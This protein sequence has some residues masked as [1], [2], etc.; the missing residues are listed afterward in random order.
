MEKISTEFIA[1]YLTLFLFYFLNCLIWVE[2]FSFMFFSFN[3]MAWRN[4]EPN[5]VLR[6][7]F[8]GFAITNPFPPVSTVFFAQIIPFSFSPE[9]ILSYMPF[10]SLISDKLIKEEPEYISYNEIKT[11]DINGKEILI[12]NKSF[13]ELPSTLYAQKIKENIL[14]IRK[15]QFWEREVFISEIIKGLFDVESVKN[16]QKNFKNNSLLLLISCNLL[17]IIIF[18]VFPLGVFMFGL[19]RIIVFMFTIIYFFTLVTIII[20]ITACLKMQSFSKRSLLRDSLM[21]M[22]CPLDAVRALDKIGKTFFIPFH[23]VAIA[24]VICEKCQYKKILK[25][26]SLDLLFPIKPNLKNAKALKTFHWYR[27]ECLVR[28]QEIIQQDGIDI[29]DF[30]VK[31]DLQDKDCVSYCPRCGSQYSIEN[32]ECSDC[33]GVKLTPINS[34]SPIMEKK[35]TIK[36]AGC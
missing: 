5:A 10:I 34:V 3:N 36:Y 11:I 26:C 20:Y 12:N 16:K 8:G 4:F 15:M 22:I 23:P 2:P 32:G 30:F 7:A 19:L 28:L 31:P 6:T 27:N 1:I 18:F 33:S 24:A 17:Y 13:G 14:K 29:A 21:M 9:G 35:H 25:K